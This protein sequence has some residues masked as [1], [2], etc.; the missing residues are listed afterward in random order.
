MTHFVFVRLPDA[1][2]AD[3]QLSGER[4]KNNFDS[5]SIG[6][7]VVAFNDETRICRFA[8]WP[9][10]AELPGE[11]EH[12]QLFL[13]LPNSIQFTGIVISYWNTF[14]FSLD[15]VHT[16]NQS[17]IFFSLLVY[18]GGLQD[19]YSLLVYQEGLGTLYSLLVYQEGLGTI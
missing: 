6:S 15:Y 7:L 9:T 1:N 18:Q 2:M 16:E 10:G 5:S 4:G 14:F 11:Q 13:L 3:F 19:L 17:I 8:R 12:C